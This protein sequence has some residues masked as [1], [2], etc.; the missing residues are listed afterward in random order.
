MVQFLSKNQHLAEKK[1]LKRIK[2]AMSH[3]HLADE[4]I[5]RSISKLEKATLIVQVKNTDSD[6]E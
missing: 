1:N 2:Y 3:P 4:M 5:L 6:S